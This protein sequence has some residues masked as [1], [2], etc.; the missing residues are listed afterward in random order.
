MNKKVIGC[1][2]LVGMGFFSCKNIKK[3][4]VQV[5]PL[6]GPAKVISDSLRFCEATCWNGESLYISNFGGDTINPLNKAG[7]G[8]IMEVSSKK[9]SIL[10]PADGR[11]NA[12]KGMCIVGNYLFVADVNAVVAFNLKD[13]SKSQKIDFPTKDSY[14]NDI[15]ANGTNLY[16][17]VTNTGNIYKL[18][19]SDPEKV[20]SQTPK[21]FATVPGANGIV[22]T[23]SVIYVAS[24]PI[25]G[26]TAA[27]N[28]IYTIKNFDKPVVEK[29]F[30]RMSQYDGL[31]LSE[32]GKSL[33]FT[34]W[35]NGNVGKINLKDLKVE[36]LVLPLQL[37][38]PA[39]LSIHKGKLYIPDLPNSKVLVY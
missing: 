3:A 31:A 6:S 37:T 30:D 26:N 28:V 10:I 21:L 23:D 2:V 19:I 16:V 20:N 1:L 12:P 5:I 4:D 39:D 9:T 34:T 38:G 32:D 27:A 35:V 14:V 11:L 8:Y 22:A 36:N 13:V 33:Y 25:D 7:K 24:Y 18:D 17:T 15:A 29:L